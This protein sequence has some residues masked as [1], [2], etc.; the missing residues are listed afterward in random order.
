MTGVQTC[1]LPIFTL[2]PIAFNGLAIPNQQV[3]F[4]T[5]TGISSSVMLTHNGAYLEVNNSTS[6]G[7]TQIESSYIIVGSNQY[8]VFGRVAAGTGAPSYV[9]LNP[10]AFNG[11]AIP[12]QQIVFGTG[13]GISSSVGLKYNGTYLEVTIHERDYTDREFLYNCR[14]Q[15]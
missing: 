8:Q 11:L 5:G 9:T 15:S 4:G 6:Q 13:T 3:A 12:N 2:N 1:A 7:I 14:E 10:I